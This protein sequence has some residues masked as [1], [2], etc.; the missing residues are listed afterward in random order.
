MGLSKMGW[1]GW[2]LYCIICLMMDGVLEGGRVVLVSFRHP[3]IMCKNS[4]PIKEGTVAAIVDSKVLGKS[5]Q[6]LR[7][8]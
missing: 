8:Q 1:N 6:L 5:E 2:E 3:Y 4:K 7:L